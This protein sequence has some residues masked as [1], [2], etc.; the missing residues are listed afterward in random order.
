MLTTI[1]RRTNT[2]QLAKQTFPLL[3]II[4]RPD[5][6]PPLPAPCPASS[7]SP[8]VLELESLVLELEPLVLELEPL[9][10]ELEPL[11]LELE[12]LVSELEPLVLELPVLLLEAELEVLPALPFL[13]A[14]ACATLQAVSWGETVTALR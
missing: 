2:A 5:G 3:D 4:D 12:P 14:A 1:V 10:S 11:V 7:P 13:L 6:W 8:P 9:V